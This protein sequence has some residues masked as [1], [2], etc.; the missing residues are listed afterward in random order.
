MKRTRSI[1][2]GVMFYG[3]KKRQ[4]FFFEKRFCESLE[5]LQKSKPQIERFSTTGYQESTLTVKMSL[6]STYFHHV[7]LRW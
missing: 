4:F 7:V 2:S 5:Q 1:F 6:L 3:T